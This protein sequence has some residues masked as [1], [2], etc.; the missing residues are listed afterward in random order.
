M[1]AMSGGVDSAVAALLTKN[2]GYE[3]CGI[4]L[5]LYNNEDVCVSK[6]KTCCSLKDVEDARSVA[7][8]LQMPYYVFNFTDN[9]KKQVIDRFVEIYINGGTPNPCIDCNRF[10]KFDQLMTRAKILDFDFVVTGHYAKN[11]YDEV[12]GRNLLKKGVDITKDQTYVLYSLTQEQLSK[13]LL[14]LGG[15]KKTEVRKIAEENG[16][17]SANKQDSQ[18]ICFV[19]NGSYADF[20]EDYTNTKSPEGDFI[21]IHGNKIGRHKGI[22]YYTIGQRKG[23]SLSLKEPGFVLSKNVADNTVTVAPEKYLYTKSLVANELNLIAYESLNKPIRVKVKTRYKQK[24]EPATI[25]QIDG[26]KIHVEFDSPQRA[27]TCGQAV[28]FYDGDVVVGGGTII[29]SGRNN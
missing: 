11:E 23:L 14:P 9:F 28:V 21:D 20:I 13:T 24:E 4:T 2:E 19:Q 8:R 25:E 1:V 27:I 7:F 26:D 6:S 15:L 3:T 16:F 18:D 5:K 22:I 29:N 17:V 12:S 10:I